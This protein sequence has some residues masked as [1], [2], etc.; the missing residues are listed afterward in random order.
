MPSRILFALAA[1][2]EESLPEEPTAPE[3][4]AETAPAAPV[5]G[6]D[7]PEGTT[8]EENRRED[9]L[10][11]WCDRQGV[12]EGPYIRFYTDGSRAVTGGWSNNQEDG[13]W[14]WWHEN[15]Q[16][17]A[18]G[19]YVRGRQSGSWTWYWSNGH[20][21]RE[22]DYLQGREAGT[23]TAWYESG[24]KKEEGLFQN[25]VKNGT[26]NY[27]LDNDENALSLSETWKNGVMVTAPKSE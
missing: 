25:G 1:C 24:R 8:V 26:W 15:G 6:L 18:R 14:V 3:P 13:T 23:W 11:R 7:C 4:A 21:S 12:Q 19:R 27:Y 10:E 17:S 5:V 20:R 2:G 16:E 22:G 9:G